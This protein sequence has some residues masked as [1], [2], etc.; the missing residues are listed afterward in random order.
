MHVDYEGSSVLH[1]TDLSLHVV[2]L[3]FV[4]GGILHS[5]L[6]ITSQSYTK[7]NTNQ[8]SLTEFLSND[9]IKLQIIID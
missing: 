7:E 5:I 9:N 8:M 6:M 4:L 1:F 2:K 3:K